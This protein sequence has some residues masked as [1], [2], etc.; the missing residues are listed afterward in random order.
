MSREGLRGPAGQV[1]TCH[2][3]LLM[4]TPRARGRWSDMPVGT[5]WVGAG[6]A[7]PPS[8]EFRPQP[9]GGQSKG[10][11]GLHLR[12][13]PGVQLVQAPGQGL[14]SRRAGPHA[15]CLFWILLP[16]GR[17]VTSW[18]E[19]SKCQ[20]PP[21]RDCVGTGLQVFMVGR[22][23]TASSHNPAHRTAPVLLELSA[24]HQIEA[25]CIY[26]SEPSTKHTL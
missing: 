4:E 11:L 23:L 9:R 14:G 13:C 21:D 8:E 7:A 5:R 18:V 12:P 1:V 26:L 19:P 20:G 3:H 16:I 10:A 6:P 17:T 24:R 25:E 2:L 22:V 15:P